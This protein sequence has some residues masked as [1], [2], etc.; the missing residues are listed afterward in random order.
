M[1]EESGDKLSEDTR[2]ALA[3][4]LESATAALESEVPA[5]IEDAS[6]ALTAASEQAA[7]ELYAAAAEEAQPAEPVAPTEADGDGDI[8]EA[9]LVDD[10]DDEEE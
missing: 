2:T 8:I 4:A 3:V 7:K 5:E 6:K 1:L 9:E 10:D